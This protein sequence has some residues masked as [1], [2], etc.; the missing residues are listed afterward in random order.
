MQFT[1]KKKITLGIATNLFIGLLS[2]LT[3]NYGLTIVKKTTSEVTNIEEPTSAAAYEMEINMLGTGMGVF[4]YLDTRAPQAR[5]RVEKDR[6]DFKKFQSQYN[7]L[8]KTQK[9]KDSGK[10]IDVL[11]QNFILLGKTLMDK[12][13]KQEVIVTK[14]SQNFLTIEEI[15]NE[16]LQANINPQGPDGVKKV[17]EAAQIEADVS[18]VGTWVGNYL[19]TPKKE[20]FERIFDNEKDFREHIK[21]FKNL[22]LTSS[23]EQRTEELEKIFN[24]TM[25]LIKEALAVDNYLH[26]NINKFV[27]LRVQMDDVLDEEIQAPTM[28]ELHASEQE[29]ERASAYVIQMSTILIPTFIFFGLT[30]ALLLLRT[31]NRPMKKLME[32]TVAVSEGDL[33]YRITYKGKDEFTELAKNFNQ[34][35]A[36]LQATTVSKERLE[37]S[38]DKLKQITINL[39]AEITERQRMEGQLQHDAL[40][41]VLTSLPNRGLCLDRLEHVVKRAKRH[42]AYLFAVLFLDL[43]RFKVVNDS[44]GHLIGDQL[45]IAFVRRLEACLRPGDTLARLGGDEFTILLDDI[46]DASSAIQTA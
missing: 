19:R 40:H 21:S 15:I 44:L 24:K 37:T 25:P 7:R 43:D 16:Q 41:D 30:A 4:S 10:K 11:Y 26:A 23:E 29:A 3:I 31:I 1:I 33:D 32:G 14:I 38:E 18:E 9:A 6:A 20:Y 36:Q 22:S 28:Q 34:M 8:A 5:E 39:L 2:M 13:D 46:K 12:K 42:E 17:K 27:D 35:V 45:L